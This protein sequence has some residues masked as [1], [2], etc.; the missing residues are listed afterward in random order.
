VTV[1]LSLW[2]AIGAGPLETTPRPPHSEEGTGARREI[3]IHCDELSL[4]IYV[5]IFHILRET[6]REMQREGGRKGEWEGEM[7]AGRESQN[8]RT[9][10]TCTGPHMIQV[11]GGRFMAW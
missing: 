11:L 3:V 10:S 8:V 1:S 6:A 5:S 9:H 4:S 7:Q 2:R